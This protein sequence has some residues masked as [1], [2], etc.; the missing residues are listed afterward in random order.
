[1]TFVRSSFQ[2]KLFLAAFASALLALAVAG[3]LFAITM[4]RETNARVE[5]TLMAEAKLASEL[6]SRLPGS[7]AT[8]DAPTLAALDLEADRIGAS[9]AARVTFIAADGRVL[10]DS[11]EPL[12]ALPG[13]ENHATRPEIVD[14]RRAGMGVSRRSS[15]TLGQD[16][17]YV[18]VPVERGPVA[19]VRVALP[20][21]SVGEQLV[22]IR[23]AIL[24]ALGLALLG[25]SVGAAILA[26]RVG[27]RVRAIAWI[28]ERY[29]QGDLTPPRLDYGDDELGVVARALD[30]SVHELGTR[31]DDLQRDRGRIAAILAG[32]I[33]GVIVVDQGGRLQ[34]VNDA[35]QQMLKIG[36]APLGRHYVETIRHPT[37]AS[38][39]AATL[40]GREPASVEFTPPRD[41][42]RTIIARAATVGSGMH[43][44][45]LVLHDISELRRADRRGR[46][47]VANVS[48]ELRTP[49]TAIR[50]YVEALSDGDLT[51]D[52]SQQFLDVIMR[53]TRRME[54]LV[55]DL[56]RLARLDAGQEKLDIT[57]CDLRAL[58]QAVA[59][60]L[61][62]ALDARHQ[63]LEM[64]IADGASSLR[65]DAAKLHDVL[66]NLIANASAYA[67]E[68]TTIT[69]A[70]RLTSDRMAIDVMD[71]GP[72]IPDAERPRIFERF[73][74]LD[75]SR[76]RD[77][78]GTGLGLAI[79]KNLVEAHGGRVSVSNRPEGG[80]R[81]TVELP[82]GGVPPA[83]EIASDSPM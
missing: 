42:S 5:V 22:G 73:Y 10:G 74:R 61:A 16:M 62:P 56:L 40:A 18:A 70:S 49:L 51:A 24:V 64:L 54:R 21:T 3:I 31:L 63:R 4:Q 41:G 20:L 83:G 66:R 76:A 50:G 26:G 43:G 78:G 33:E 69:V 55:Q 39:V 36:E 52:E 58:V 11:A 65:A 1:V 28:A 75:E 35:A 23:T 38:L 6:L 2:I 45:V 57:R 44:V 9:I 67:P 80:A 19:F 59:G 37:I 60:D 79:V 72:G 30:D 53:H 8:V 81:F 77:P 29:R 46:D 13:M 7:A 82:A 47:F 17:L 68:G 71:Q 12:D 25:A 14:A 48:H 15:S 32:M 27:Q 34:L